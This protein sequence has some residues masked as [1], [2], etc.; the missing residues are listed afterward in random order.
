MVGAKPA[1]EA[2][3]Y[4]DNGSVAQSPAPG[5]LGIRT[6]DGPEAVEAPLTCGGDTGDDDRPKE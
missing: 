1:G 4:R 2:D 3:P 6:S 5:G